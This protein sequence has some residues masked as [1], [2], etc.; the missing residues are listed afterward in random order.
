MDAAGKAIEINPNNIEARNN[1]GYALLVTDKIDEAIETFKASLAIEPGH[2]KTLVNLINAYVKAGRTDL[3]AQTCNT[4]AEIDPA[5]A[6]EA[7]AI[8]K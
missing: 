1:L 5:S 7:R 2:V 6:A 4:L 3:A 8:I